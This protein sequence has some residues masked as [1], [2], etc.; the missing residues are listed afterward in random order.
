MTESNKDK[1]RNLSPNTTR[2]QIR[3]DNELLEES[4]KIAKELGVTW[5]AFVQDAV[6]AKTESLK[7]NTNN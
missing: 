3:W 4:Q 2:K 1:H 6:K 7:E 5:S